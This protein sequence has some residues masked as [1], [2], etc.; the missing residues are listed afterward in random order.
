M[1]LIKSPP[2][3]VGSSPMVVPLTTDDVD[4]AFLLVRN[5]L[6]AGHTFLPAQS[7]FGLTV[8]SELTQINLNKHM[9]CV[10]GL[11][12]LLALIMCMPGLLP[13]AYEGKGGR[14]RLP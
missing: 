14:T 6:S 10:Q 13:Q 9:T 3:L 1:D 8:T 11:N 4:L 5:S 12:S 2:N 7:L